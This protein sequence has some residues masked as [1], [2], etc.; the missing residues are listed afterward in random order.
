MNLGKKNK[1]IQKTNVPKRKTT[2]RDEPFKFVLSPGPT[3]ASTALISQLS[4]IPTP[5]LGDTIGILFR[6]VSFIYS[7]LF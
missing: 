6:F 2:N 4:N 1:C 5:T 3:V 7:F